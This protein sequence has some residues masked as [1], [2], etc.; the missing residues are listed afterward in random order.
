MS[1][2]NM[3][4]GRSKLVPHID[5]QS[6][7]RYIVSPCPKL[8]AYISGKIW[9]KRRSSLTDKPILGASPYLIPTSRNLEHLTPIRSG[10]SI[11][12]LPFSCSLAIQP[13]TLPRDFNSKTRSPVDRNLCPNP[14]WTRLRNL[15][16][17]GNTSQYAHH[18]Y[19]MLLDIIHI[20]FSKCQWPS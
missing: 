19:R 8:G 20:L 11:M 10:V 13:A 5:G 9:S 15:G 1:C 12:W 16:V 4:Q 3:L 18:F 6:A 7:K 14:L 17:I 2:S